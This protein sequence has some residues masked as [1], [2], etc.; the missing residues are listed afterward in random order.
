MAKDQSGFFKQKKEWSVIKDR[1]LG[2]YLPQYFQKVLFTHRPIYYVDCFAGKGKFDDGQVGSPMI[3]MDSICTSIARSKLDPQELNGAIHPYFIEL[4]H[5]KDLEENLK[6][7]Y[8]SPR[9]YQVID[10]KFEEKIC[11]I[12]S[13][14]K[15]DNVFLYIDPYGIKALDSHLFA[16]IQGF[17]FRSFEMLINFNS[18]GFFRDA[19]Q[20]LRV[21]YK[22]DAALRDLD[23]LVEYEPPL[24]SPR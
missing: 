5:A 3:A 2:G 1:L 11:G 12:L 8:K 20:V 16:E 4:N 19:C 21:D 13:G 17:E 10:G 23:D 22:N 15:G 9:I 24:S 14:R 18:F 7:T 6:A